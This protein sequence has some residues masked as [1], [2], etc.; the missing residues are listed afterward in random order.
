M[1]EVMEEWKTIPIFDGRFRMNRHGVVKNDKTGNFMTPYINSGNGYVM[2]DLSCDGA[3]KHCTLHRLVAKTYIEN[4]NNLPIVMHKD[5]NRLNYSIDNLK[6]GTYLENNKQA[7]DEHRMTV[8]RPDNRKIYDVYSK[9]GDIIVCNGVKEIISLIGY[10]T[11]SC[12]RNYIFRNSCI[13]KGKYK[14]YKIRLHK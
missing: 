10:G 7:I 3:H 2:V 6:W 13:N 4:P 14:G 11:D 12:I 1:K 5:N 8:P 9:S